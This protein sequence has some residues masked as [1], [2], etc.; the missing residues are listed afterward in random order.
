MKTICTHVKKSFE[1]DQREVKGTLQRQYGENAR[2]HVYQRVPKEPLAPQ[3]TQEGE[4]RAYGY[5]A[6]FRRWLYVGDLKL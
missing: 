1:G 5:I 6:S 4:V 2:P 3:N